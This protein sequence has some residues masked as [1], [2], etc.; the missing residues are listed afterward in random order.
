M[1]NAYALACDKK[2][3]VDTIY[4]KA[5]AIGNNLLYNPPQYNSPNT[6][7]E[8]NLDKANALLDQAGWAKSGQYRAKGGVPM[9]ITYSTTVNAVRQ[10]TQQVVKDGWEK[11]GIQVELKSV[12]AAVFFAPGSGGN[13]DSA[14]LFYNDVEMFTN[15]NASPDPFSYMEGLTTAQIAQKAN[16]WSGNNYARWS[17]K[18]YDAAIEQLRTELDEKKRAELYIKANDIEVNDFAEIPLVARA[19]VSAIAKTLEVGP[20]ST[21]ESDTWNIGFWIRK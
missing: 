11:I 15:G 5:G 14:S 17:N 1:R 13:P 3:I 8:Y 6:R 18:E 7:S 16:Q 2:T 12:D 21:W 10:K 4:G 20:E 19:S 9:R